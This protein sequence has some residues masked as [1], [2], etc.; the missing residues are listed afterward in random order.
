MMTKGFVWGEIS[1]G[2]AGQMP[3]RPRDEEDK[4]R[5]V[6]VKMN[7]NKEN[8]ELLEADVTVE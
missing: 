8:V 6:L 1:F 7:H 3:T 2:N 5:N 4:V